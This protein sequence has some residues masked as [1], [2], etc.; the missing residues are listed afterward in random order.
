[1]DGTELVTIRVC[2]N[3]MEANLFRSI[4]ESDGVDS[5]I[6]DEVSR[7]YPPISMFSF[8]VRLVV[9]KRDE[10]RA[11]KILANF[12]AQSLDKTEDS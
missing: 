3:I 2:Q 11:R 7:Q 6:P 4:L 10:A 1:M 9:R 12:D 8:G 5:L